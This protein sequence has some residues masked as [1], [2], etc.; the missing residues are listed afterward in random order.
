MLNVMNLT[1]RRCNR[2]RGFTLAEI[3]IAL[4][5]LGIGMTMVAAVFPAAMKFNEASNNSTLGTIICENAF[6]LSH[7]ALYSDDVDE[8]PGNPI[9]L[10]T[11]ADD[12]LDD[13][14]TFPE[15]H[16]PTGQGTS[17]T[18]FVL[19]ARKLSAD[20]DDYQ[21]VTV[22]YRKT[23]AN[24]KARLVA[25]NCKID[26]TDGKKISA[27]SHLRIGSPLIDRET[28]TFAFIDSINTSGTAG[29]LDIDLSKRNM[30]STTKA[31]VLVEATP[32]GSPISEL[33]RSPA[34]GAMSTLTGL[35]P[36]P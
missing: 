18:G 15:Q 31:Y 27:A 17:K 21:F 11:F 24:N 8:S 6:V 5:I 28:G 19:M 25:I 3:M 14:I 33:R 36:K 7:L 26:K 16:Y 29:T 23:N 34:I 35:N 12:M 4:G 32:G 1:D 13:F 22:A 30:N 9:E 10:K 2:N 20:G